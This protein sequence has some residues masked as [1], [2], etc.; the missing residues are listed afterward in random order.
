M[1]VLHCHVFAESALHSVEDLAKVEQILQPGD[2]IRRVF[3][4]GAGASPAAL[5]FPVSPRRRNVRAAS[6]R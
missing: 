2:S 1:A 5:C 3:V 4:V 6:V